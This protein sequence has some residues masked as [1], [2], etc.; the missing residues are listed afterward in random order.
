MI[1]TPMIVEPLKN[2]PSDIPTD[3]QRSSTTTIPSS[4]IGSFS[5]QT[6]NILA[7]WHELQVKKLQYQ[8]PTRVGFWGEKHQNYDEFDQIME[9]DLNYQLK[10]LERQE[11]EQYQRMEQ[12][13]QEQ[14]QQQREYSTE[15]KAEFEHY[16]MEILKQSEQLQQRIESQIN[17]LQQQKSPL[18]SPNIRRQ[19]HQV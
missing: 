9:E 18:L 4:N 7:Q 11:L 8:H 14:L 5:I 2:V 12:T 15:Q 17:V 10:E 16:C 13:L 3:Y 19:V 1:T 6:R